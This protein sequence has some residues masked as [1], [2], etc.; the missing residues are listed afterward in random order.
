MFLLHV[1]DTSHSVTHHGKYSAH[2]LFFFNS[3]VMNY[4][5]TGILAVDAK[6]YTE[7]NSTEMESNNV[8]PLCVAS[9]T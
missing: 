7:L 9:F 3:S 1:T 4:F 8:W 6:E 2:D 5:R